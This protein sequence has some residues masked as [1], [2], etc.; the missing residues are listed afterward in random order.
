MSENGIKGE[1]ARYETFRVS[2]YEREQ[3]GGAYVM[4]WCGA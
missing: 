3:D 4:D 1:S 2:V